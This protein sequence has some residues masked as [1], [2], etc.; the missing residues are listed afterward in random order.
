MK[1]VLVVGPRETAEIDFSGLA[2][3]FAKSRLTGRAQL[4]EALVE[5]GAPR[6]VGMSYRWRSVSSS[7]DANGGMQ[8]S[9]SLEH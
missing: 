6:N 3:T 2:E 9:Q 5:A 4:R 1:C 7:A 8:H